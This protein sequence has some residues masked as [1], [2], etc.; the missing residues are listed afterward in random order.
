MA[1]GSN[2]KVQQARSLCDEARWADVLTLARRWQAETT[3]DAQ[4]FFYEGVALAGLGKFVAAETAYY[5]AL[6]LDAQDFTTWNNLASLLFNSLKQPAEGV[7]CLAQAMRLDP[8]NKLG[9]ANLAAM[10]GELGRYAEA[11]ECAERALA[12]DPDMVEAQLYRGRAG[13]ALG[14][15]ELAR[16]ACE[17]LAKLSPDKFQRAK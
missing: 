2:P 1:A 7:K 6:G 10:Y 8:G 17:A 16:A 9:W 3:D 5:R 14:Q 4:A 11:L 13:L 15:P 12:L